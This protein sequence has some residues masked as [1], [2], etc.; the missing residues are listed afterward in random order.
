LGTNRGRY[1]HKQPTLDQCCKTKLDRLKRT[2]PLWLRKLVPLR[3]RF[4]R[5]P[6]VSKAHGEAQPTLR[7]TPGFSLNNLWLTPIFAEVF[8]WVVFGPDDF[9]AFFLLATDLTALEFLP[10]F[11]FRLPA[12]G[13]AIGVAGERILDFSNFG[14]QIQ[15]GKIPI[16]AQTAG[17]NLRIRTNYPL[18][19]YRSK[20]GKV[21]EGHVLFPTRSLWPEAL[22]S[23]SIIAT[24]LIIVPSAGPSS[25]L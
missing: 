20:C 24:I 6:Q 8:S 25:S 7:R 18:L 2:L 21:S 15:E 17:V 1:T 22:H 10:K 14:D 16:Y 5:R 3:G 4:Q 23:A 19:H 13:A 12:L 9:F 11:I